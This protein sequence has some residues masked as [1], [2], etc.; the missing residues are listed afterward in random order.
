MK[1]RLNWLAGVCVVFVVGIGLSAPAIFGQATQDS[2]PESFQRSFPM[3]AG[4]T[5]VVEN[6]KGTIH[7]TGSDT[8]QVTVSVRKI[9]TGG[10][11]KERQEWMAGTKVNFDHLPDHVSVRVEYPDWNCVFCVNVSDGVELT[12]AVPRETNVELDGN[13]PDM[14]VSSIE[15]DIR[16]SSNRSAI[17]VKSTAGAIRI[18]TNRGD[19][20]LS[21]VAIKGRL[22]LTSNRAEAVIEAKSIAGNADLETERGSIVVRMP[23]TVGVNLD[24]VGGRRS[25]F[26]C[27]FPVTT[28]EN[29]AE[30]NDVSGR[31]G[32]DGARI[33]GA[34]NQGGPRMILRTTRG[35]ISLEKAS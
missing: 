21:D 31:V 20:R 6:R 18:E 30:L 22:E 33:S 3:S 35:T 9:F 16:I 4:G 8:N 7:V 27:D 25:S 13:R 5:L 11:D 23:S 17:A 10:T 28:N 32:R 19:V 14:A 26:H 12:I 1:T 34:L 15:G 29:G 2:N 24:Y